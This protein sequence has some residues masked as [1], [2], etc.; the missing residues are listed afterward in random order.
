MFQPS[1]LHLY[2]IKKK[3]NDVYVSD[4][5]FKKTAFARDVFPYCFLSK[6]Q[7]QLPQKK[8]FLSLLHPF[9]GLGGKDHFQFFPHPGQGILEFF[10]HNWNG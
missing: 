1:K 6:K 10:G 7:G 4:G 2:R 3:K 5:P 8:K 9:H